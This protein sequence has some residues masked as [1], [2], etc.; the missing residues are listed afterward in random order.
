[1]MLNNITYSAL[2]AAADGSLLKTE[3][4]LT[5]IVASYFFSV[6]GAMAGV[7]AVEAYR[8]ESD[9]H[10][11]HFELILFSCCVGGV[12]IWFLHFTGMF[13]VEYM[14]QT[15]AGDWVALSITYE[16]IMTV[17]SWFFAFAAVHAG[18]LIASK[19]TFFGRSRVEATSALTKMV[20]FRQ[21][22]RQGNKVRFAALFMKPQR[23]IAGGV[24]AGLGILLMHYTGMSA[25]HQAGFKVKWKAPALF[26]SVILAVVV[27]SVG[28]WI[29]FR[30]LQWKPGVESF[31]V[32]A[33]FVIALAVASVHYSG[34]AAAEYHVDHSRLE[35]DSSGTVSREDI[36]TF[37]CFFSAFM[38]CISQFFL[39]GYA[40]KS[41]VRRTTLLVLEFASAAQT[42][43]ENATTLNEARAKIG[44]LFNKAVKLAESRDK[45][46]LSKTFEN[47]KTHVAATMG[48]TKP[49]PS[50]QS[51]MSKIQPDSA[52]TDA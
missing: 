23:F 42:E 51:S 30:F 48:G 37:G 5:W 15:S 34:M 19:D 10:M 13:A 52:V 29:I 20:T 16:P 12:G 36:F 17:A 25:V 22:V 41:V 40:R 39:I 50:H 46:S 14:V 45:E 2:Q 31:R 8:E 9:K 44:V 7:N 11:K 47:N 18:A 27:P 24:V 38:L 1:M 3:W 26:V 32:G 4:S 21:I 49:H 28:F 6:C 35:V 43:V 33:A